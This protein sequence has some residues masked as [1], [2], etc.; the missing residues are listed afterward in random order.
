MAIA[1]LAFAGIAAA[2]KATPGVWTTRG[3]HAVVRLGAAQKAWFK[4]T[5]ELCLTATV[6]GKYRRIS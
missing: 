1:S 5:L 3:D 6:I 4:Q 2:S